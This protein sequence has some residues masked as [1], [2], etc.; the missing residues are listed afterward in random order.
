[1]GTYI[2]IEIGASKRYC[3]ECRFMA[4]EGE[5]ESDGCRCMVFRKNLRVSGATVKRLRECL[6]AGELDC[7]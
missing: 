2:T 3:A 1:M 5:R 6:R 7:Y 4:R